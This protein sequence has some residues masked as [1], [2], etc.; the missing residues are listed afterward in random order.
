MKKLT[1]AISSLLILLFTTFNANAI[2]VGVSLI[3]SDFDGTGTEKVGGTNSNTG[4]ASKTTDYGSLFFESNPSDNGWVVGIDWIPA[5]ATFVS[6][7]KTQTNITSAVSATE[8]KT[9]KVEADIDNHL[10]LYVE[11]EVYNGVYLKAGVIQVDIT[12]NESIGTGSTYP[13]DELFG[14]T[15]GIGYR[16][17]MDNL[18]IKL[19]AAYSDYDSIDLSA[20]NTTNT[21]TGDFDATS[22]KI[23]IGY[24]F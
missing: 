5:S 8:T 11:K 23:S 10:T 21:V 9:Q 19:E 16:Y 24:S 12:T 15:Y 1:L 4:S 2:S 3:Q 13:D 18:F 6:E 14:H 22:G 20:T 17:N 7:S